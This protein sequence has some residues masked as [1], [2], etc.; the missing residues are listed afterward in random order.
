MKRGRK[1][2]TDLARRRFGDWSVTTLHRM[3]RNKGKSTRA[4]WLCY[5]SCGGTAWVLASNLLRGSSRG[6]AT[7]RHFRAANP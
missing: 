3:R 1:P 7:C 6:C 4:E 2:V 5:C